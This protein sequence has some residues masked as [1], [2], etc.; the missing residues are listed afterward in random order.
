[1]IEWHEPISSRW[2]STIRSA[3]G[4]LIEATRQWW[5]LASTLCVA[6]IIYVLVFPTPFLLIDDA[7]RRRG[8]LIL[9]ASGITLMSLTVL[10]ATARVIS[11]PR[12][13]V[14]EK[15]LWENGVSRGEIGGVTTIRI[16][17]RY[18]QVCFHGGTVDG[19]IIGVPSLEVAESIERAL[20]TSAA[21]D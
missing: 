3:R 10:W 8:T 20:N 13:G 15:Q 9:F 18:A 4:L 12:Y 2:N 14:K 7:T 1:M 21:G 19:L 5:I 6:L 17:P 11:S 16:H